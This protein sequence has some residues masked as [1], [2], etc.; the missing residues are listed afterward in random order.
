MSDEFDLE[1]LL[2]ADASVKE[3]KG[4]GFSAAELKPRGADEGSFRGL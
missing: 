3:L 2:D 4:V 1:Q